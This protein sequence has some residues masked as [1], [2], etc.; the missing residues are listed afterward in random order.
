MP[1]PDDG[2]TTATPAP[3]RCTCHADYYE[4]ELIDPACGVEGT[5]HHRGDNSIEPEY[6]DC[7]LCGDV[8]QVGR[9]PWCKGVLHFA[10]AI[11]GGGVPC[12]ACRVRELGAEVAQ[13]R[14]LAEA[15]VA[16][17]RE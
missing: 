8:G 1:I 12:P 7:Y 5:E 17:Q 6:G 15:E 13:E 11:F 4:R 9:T 2:Y 16:R 10:P 14:K 3:A